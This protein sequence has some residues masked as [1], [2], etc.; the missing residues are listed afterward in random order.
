M[1]GCII[2]KRILPEGSIVTAGMVP[3]LSL[4]A[5]GLVGLAMRRKAVA[6]LHM[7]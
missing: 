7:P 2:K 4:F 6:S 1:A 3:T 5:L